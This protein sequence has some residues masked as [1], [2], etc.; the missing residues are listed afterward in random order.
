M[1]SLSVNLAALAAGAEAAGTAVPITETGG[2]KEVKGIWD[3]SDEVAMK[4]MLPGSVVLFHGD[5]PRFGFIPLANAV[6][7]KPTGL[8]VKVS[9]TGDTTGQWYKE[10]ATGASDNR[11]L[12]SIKSIWVGVVPGNKS[13]KPPWQLGSLPVELWPV[14]GSDD[15]F[16]ELMVGHGVRRRDRRPR[17]D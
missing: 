9:M 6:Q 10:T 3:K 11:L 2:V 13:G 7:S 12:G 8:E 5:T 14:T 17:A 16:E 4:A 15:R 1:P